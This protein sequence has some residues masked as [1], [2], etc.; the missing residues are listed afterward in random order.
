M[1]KDMAAEIEKL[2]LD[3]L[4]TREKNGVY[5]SVERYEQVIC[6]NYVVRYACSLSQTDLKHIPTHRV[7]SSVLS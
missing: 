2:K 7:R 3:L 1:I 5:L 6:S 4:C